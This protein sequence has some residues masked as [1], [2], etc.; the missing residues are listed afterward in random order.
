MNRR[1]F[2]F[3]VAALAAVPMLLPME[4]QEKITWVEQGFDFDNQFAI[5]GEYKGIRQAIRLK[6]R[7][8]HV[9]AHDKQLMKQILT[10]WFSEQ[11][12]D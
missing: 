2:V 7:V 6:K 5:A 9:D 11:I 1:D 3:S 10:D 8:I 12:Y 4:L